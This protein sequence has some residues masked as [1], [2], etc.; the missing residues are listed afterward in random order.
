MNSGCRND[1]FTCRTGWKYE[2]PDGRD[3]IVERRI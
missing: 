3:W 2:N 1:Q